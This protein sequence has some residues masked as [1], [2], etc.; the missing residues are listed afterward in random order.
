MLF[1]TLIKFAYGDL[2]PDSPKKDEEVLSVA[3]MSESLKLKDEALRIQQEAF[4]RQ[5]EVVRAVVQEN[6][7]LKEQV[8]LTL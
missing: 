6:Q 5:E 3:Q 7:M 4:Q 1:F 8:S 2:V